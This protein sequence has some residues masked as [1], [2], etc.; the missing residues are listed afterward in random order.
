MVACIPCGLTALESEIME[1]TVKELIEMS[2]AKRP[3]TAVARCC[4]IANGLGY[5]I[6]RDE[7]PCLTA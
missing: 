3:F 5:M 2:K 6:V 4:L 1:E 7:L